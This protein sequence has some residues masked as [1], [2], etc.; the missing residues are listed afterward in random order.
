ML[1]EVCDACR[2]Y[3]NVIAAFTPTPPEMLPAEDLAL[4]HKDHITQE[5]GYMRGQ[6][7]YKLLDRHHFS[8]L[9]ERQGLT[10]ACRAESL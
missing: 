7:S 3:L 4:L 1:V 10:N 2:G 9:H 8:R 5:H 6:F